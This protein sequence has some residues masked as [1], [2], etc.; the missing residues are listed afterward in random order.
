VDSLISQE[1]AAHN[2]KAVYKSGMDKN[3]Q[4]RIYVG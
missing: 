1:K 4:R 3:S 2:R